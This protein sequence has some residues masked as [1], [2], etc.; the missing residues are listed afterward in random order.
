MYKAVI[1][2]NLK[3]RVHP[4]NMFTALA[5]LDGTDGMD[6]LRELVAEGKVEKVMMP[7]GRNNR[8]PMYRAV[9]EPL[10]HSKEPHLKAVK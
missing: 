7:H 10:E 6:E 2:K 8:F 3:G 4:V 9:P 5:G 1:L